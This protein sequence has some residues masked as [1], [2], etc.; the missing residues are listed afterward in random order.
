MK[1]VVI[2]SKEYDVEK[3]LELT[4]WECVDTDLVEIGKLVNLKELKLFISKDISAL[5]P[6]ANLTNLQEML[7]GDN[8]ISDLTPLANLRSLK[9]LWLYNN[10]ISDI[11]PLASLTDLMTVYL[12]D[13][14]ISEEDISWLKQQL[15]HTDVL[16]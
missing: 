1:T 16:F 15:W 5:S 8:Q 13:N 11:K 14:N 12:S 2:K 3:T 4:L 9:N 7:L 10:K 6:L